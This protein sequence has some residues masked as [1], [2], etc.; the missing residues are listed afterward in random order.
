M[1]VDQAQMQNLSSLFMPVES[2]NPCLIL[3]VRRENIVGD[4]MEVLR[5]SKNVDYKKP[6][7]VK[8]T[9][10]PSASISGIWSHQREI[11][12]A[13]LVTFHTGDFCGWGGSRCWRCEKGVLSPDHERINGSKIWNVPILWGVQAHL[14]FKQ[15]NWHLK[16]FFLHICTY[17]GRL[18]GTSK[19]F[20]NAADNLWIVLIWGL[21]QCVEVTNSL[22]SFSCH[23]FFLPHLMLYSSTLFHFF[24]YLIILVYFYQVNIRLSVLFPVNS[25]WCVPGFCLEQHSFRRLIMLIKISLICPKVM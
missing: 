10:S 24:C 14:V 22:I 7:K 6:L 23:M 11:N 16:S 2:V 12:S 4:T 18:Y 19:K 1:A 5:K 21:V 17:S 3:V 25:H 20:G 8:D 9:E 15:G 13:D